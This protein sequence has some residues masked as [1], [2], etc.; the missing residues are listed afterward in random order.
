MTLLRE[1]SKDLSTMSSKMRSAAKR[2]LF[3]ESALLA[4]EFQSRSPVDSGKYRSGW[5]IARG[6]FSSNGFAGVTIFNNSTDYADLMEYG[7]KKN[8]AP[9]YFPI[10]K[11]GKRKTSKKLILN[12]GLIW[13]GGMKPGHAKT[14]GG[15]IGPGLVDNN[16]R[17]IKLVNN[18]ADGMIGAIK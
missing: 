17:L 13:A 16:R 14:V 2:A 18:V 15:A 10:G 3:A 1:I 5:R 6:R 7:A 12:R 9:W 8:A 4:K 11:S